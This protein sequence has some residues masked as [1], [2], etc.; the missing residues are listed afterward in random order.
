M[1]K[2]ATKAARKVCHK[3]DAINT[4]P[5]SLS[6]VMNGKVKMAVPK[7]K[8]EAKCAEISKTENEKIPAAAPKI[9][10]IK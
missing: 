2:K 4:Q 8:A 7:W 3:T 1:Q 9:S 5:K 10:I 6:Q